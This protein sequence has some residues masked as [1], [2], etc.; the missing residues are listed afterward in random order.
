MHRSALTEAPTNFSVISFL[1]HFTNSQPITIMPAKPKTARREHSNET[2]SVTHA[3]D[4]AGKSHGKIADYVKI[5]QS[6]VTRILQRASKNPN[7]PYRKTKHVG[8]S[9]KLNA[10]SQRALICVST[11]PLGT[12]S[13]SGHTLSRRTVQSYLKTAGYLRFKARRKPVLTQ[14]HKD[15]RLRWAR[16]HVDWTLEDWI[17]V[18][19][20]DEAI[21]K[22]GL[23]TR[24]CYVTRRPGTAIESQYLKLTFKSGRSTLGIWG[25]ITFEKK[26]PVHFLAKKGRMTLEIYV[27]QFFWRL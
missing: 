10:W 15:A 24:S 14:K 5:S 16:E 2:I 18:I 9:I 12:P 22:T 6:T 8:R 19:W 7:G 21:F 11:W 3:L 4:S 13:K 17:R 25:A 1:C 23:D 26:G 27:D 20:T